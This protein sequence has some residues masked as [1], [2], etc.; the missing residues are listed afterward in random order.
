MPIVEDEDDVRL[1]TL[2][3]QNERDVN[4]HTDYN[5]ATEPLILKDGPKAEEEEKDAAGAGKAGLLLTSVGSVKP[6]AWGALTKLSD[7]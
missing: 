1:T 7:K 2:S 6:G 4:V 3:I 5:D